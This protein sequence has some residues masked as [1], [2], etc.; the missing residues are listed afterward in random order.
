MGNGTFDL[1]LNGSIRRV[2]QGEIGD[3][4]PR[5]WHATV[6]FR[7]TGLEVTVLNSVN[8]LARKLCR[9]GL[10]VFGD[11]IEEAG[12]SGEL[13][14]SARR[15]WYRAPDSPY[16]GRSIGHTDDPLTIMP[17]TLDSHGKDSCAALLK[18]MLE[19][20]LTDKRWRTELQVRQEVPRD[21]LL[22]LS[23]EK[24]VALLAKPLDQLHRILKRLL[25]V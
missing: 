11:L 15:A 19:R 7:P 23:P 25:E 18:T 6:F 14:V 10:N 1:R 4:S 3:P 17:V 5:T 2:V 20:L 13:C 8:N 9:S 16:K 24:Q 12:K 21:K 22:A